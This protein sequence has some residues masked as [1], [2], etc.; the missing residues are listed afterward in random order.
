MNL[1]ADNIS[2]HFTEMPRKTKIS[3]ICHVDIGTNSR[4]FVRHEM[5]A[6]SSISGK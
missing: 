4:P 5:R 3:N 1:G 2:V 6:M